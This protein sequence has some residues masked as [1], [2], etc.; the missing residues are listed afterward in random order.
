MKILLPLLIILLSILN[1]KAQTICFTENKGQVYDQNYKA[2]PDVL[3]GVMA[4]NMAVHIK[5]T[6]VSYQLY[7]VD[8]WK[9][10]TKA[11]FSLGEGRG[12]EAKFPH[13]EIEEQTIYRIDLTWVNA[14]TN[15]TK[16]M[17]EALPG[18]NNY[19]LE[20][21]PNG[22]LNVKSYKGFTLHNLYKG[23]NL[24]YYEKQGQLKH[25]YIVAPHA[26][27]KQIQLKV[28]GAKVSLN[29]DGSLLLNTPLGKV[30][31]GAPLVYQ[32]GKQLKAK[33]VITGT[34]P[35]RSVS[36]AIENYNPNY[37]LII[38][39]ITCLW[40]TYYGD[41]GGDW[42]NSCS[43]D[44]LGNVYM[45][46]Y[47]YLS[48]GTVIATSGSQ[49]S[50]YGGGDDA[51]LVKFDGNGV[52]QWGTYYGGL[53]NDV[54]QSCIN[55]TF[56]NIYISGYTNSN[57]AIAS[58][59]SYQSAFGGG[60]TDAFL[61]KFD[62]NGVR[63]WGT[64][65]GGLWTDVSTSCSIDPSGNIYLCGYTSDTNAVASIIATVGSHQVAY[66]GGVWDA[67][68]VKFD[69]SGLRLWGTYYGG[70]GWD[71]GVSCST[72]NLGNVYLSGFT[73]SIT[74]TVIASS[75]SHQ[76]IYGGLN[77]DSFLVK[78]DGSGVRQ[79][80]TYY[81]DT[82]DNYAN[83]CSI[84]VLGNVYMTGYTFSSSSSGTAIASVGSHQYVFGGWFDAFLVK[85]D[86]NGVRQWGTYYGD[87]GLESG[88][89]CN[90]DALGN[91]YM[92]GVTSSSIAIASSG[93]YQ[94]SFGGLYDAFLAKFDGNGV[95]QWG[96]YYGGIG[97]ELAFS[98]TVDASNN[99]YMC[100]FTTD[101]TNALVTL[102]SHQSAF[103]GGM[104]DA[105]LVKLINCS[106]L[107]PTGSVSS[108]FCSGNTLNFTA[109]V[110]GSV[111]PTYAWAGPNS[112]TSS[113]QNP[114]ITGANAQNIG[115]YTLTVNN[116]GCVETTT[117]E[118][119]AIYAANPTASLISTACLGANLNFSGNIAGS[120]TATYAW[121]GPNGFTSTSQNPS[122]TGANTQNI[123]TYTLTIN[124]HGCIATTT[125]EVSA[126]NA[127]PTIIVNSG[128][129][130]SGNSFSLTPS[131]A[132]TYTYSG[133]S[134]IVSPISSSVYS[135]TG[136]NSFGCVGLAI[137][138]VSVNANP[139]ITIN[140][141]TI[142]SGNSFTLTP[143]GA[144]NYT[145][146][147]GSA[148]VNPISN[149]IY[150]VTGTNS[151]GCIGS[152]ISNV[153]IN[154]S[155]TI[156]VNSG[157]IC[158]GNNFTIVPTG[159]S[160]YTIQGGNNVVS[161]T[162]NNTYTTIGTSAEGCLSNIATSTI[163]VNNLPIILSGTSNSIICGPLF[164]DTAT[165]TAS[166][167]TNYTWSN[168]SNAS[169]IV[170][171]PSITTTYSIN[172]T[173]ANGCSNTAFITQSVS[174]CTGIGK[175]NA[176][177]Y[178]LNIYPNPANDVL[179]IVTSLNAGELVSIQIINNL[180]QVLYQSEIHGN[181]SNIPVNQLAN[182]IYYVQLVNTSHQT[183]TQKFIIQR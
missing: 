122:I 97:S 29:K 20:S 157:A 81:G 146:S 93:S 151:F 126:V 113:T 5:N 99:I 57:S 33:W 128:T 162:S 87:S 108:T 182:G 21:C 75:G 85:F 32:N 16:T 104:T 140:S 123:G 177:S 101:S 50:A 8:K 49:Q 120:N 150:S 143:S 111:L 121:S 7:R 139:T 43:T 125:T 44:A 77:Y 58:S 132:I 98:S 117:T 91:V 60:G 89:S 105:F 106:I 168:G 134:A 118:V 40:G 15:F 107:T 148:V 171:S 84:D 30:Q 46:G 70:S 152:A 67:F 74:G 26:N 62:A 138:N 160:A 124:D 179:N 53:G 12:V 36:F 22:A 39:P 3:F 27:Y 83:S 181:E 23:I 10:V 9:E 69:A 172:G 52:R 100:G 130:C 13:K 166:G 149:S 68:L 161:P 35:S 82:G 48:A 31:E 4:G 6:G 56:G 165:L 47:S 131:G 66:G 18:Y 63:Q 34:E 80:G 127:N 135:V 142:C 175:L 38:D 158:V 183:T 129:I 133:G 73:G 14:N 88:Y 65:Y 2:R 71:N 86:A 164:Q 45:S 25:D 114:S 64:Y 61:V 110:T 24:H 95:R 96:T 41:S 176:T 51:F 42:G 79:W 173:D 72:D 163:N 144:I 145:Y 28:E 109:N 112:F 137:S 147:G 180:G 92:S 90:L 178:L 76:S 170:V 55:D 37:E 54:S 78:F 174:A 115:I 141:G 136:T 155:P 156:T 1:A 169:S 102:G 19:Y 153:S 17:D 154:I 116:N 159:A 103:G 94:S 167:A 119:T 59:G 11:P